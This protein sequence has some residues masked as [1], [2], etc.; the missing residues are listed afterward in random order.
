MTKQEAVEKLREAEL[1]I[2]A[3]IKTLKNITGK[4][5]EE[6]LLYAVY[7]VKRQGL[8]NATAYVAVCLSNPFLYVVSPNQAQAAA[9][10]R[11]KVKEFY[12]GQDTSFPSL[13]GIVVP[14]ALPEDF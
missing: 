9:E 2:K 11:D 4:E 1:I 10:L 5:K 3:L 6:P 8:P 13:D 14:D 7:E 12:T